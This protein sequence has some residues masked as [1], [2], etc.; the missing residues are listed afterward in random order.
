MSIRRAIDK[1][2]KVGFECRKEWDGSYSV[3]F[4]KRHA[5]VVGV[6]EEVAYSLSEA[7]NCA[8]TEA[9][10]HLTTMVPKDFKQTN[11]FDSTVE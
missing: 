1:L 6:P 7:L 8:I 11:L 2:S 4:G 10:T 9:R 3:R 5:V